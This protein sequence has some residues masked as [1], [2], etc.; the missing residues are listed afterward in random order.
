MNGKI[1]YGFTSDKNTDYYETL[2]KI[3]LYIGISEDIGEIWIINSFDY[4]VI[5]L[6]SYTYN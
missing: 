3:Q 2:Y 6:T 1:W 4:F 5:E